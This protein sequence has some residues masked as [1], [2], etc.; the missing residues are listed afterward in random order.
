M[1]FRRVSI[2]FLVPFF[3]YSSSYAGKIESIPEHALKDEVSYKKKTF[4]VE[5]ID[6]WQ[7]NHNKPATSVI[8]DFKRYFLVNHNDYL[9]PFIARP[10]LY[11]TYYKQETEFLGKNSNRPNLV[12]CIKREDQETF[13]LTG[14]GKGFVGSVA[15]ATTCLVAWYFLKK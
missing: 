15:V 1:I 13:A 3:L 8:R 11:K 6:E 10:A 7:E 12:E 5:K 2:L 9:I 4:I 14:F